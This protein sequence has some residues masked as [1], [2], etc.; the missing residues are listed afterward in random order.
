M[1]KRWAL[2][3][4]LVLLF[5]GLS[6]FLYM[7]RPP[8]VLIVNGERLELPGPAAVSVSANLKAAGLELGPG[9]L[10]SPPEGTWSWNIGQITIEQSAQ[11]SIYADGELIS[12]ASTSRQAGELVRQA[13]LQLGPYD[14]LY[15]NGALT[16]PEAVMDFQP[17]RTIDLRRAVQVRLDDGQETLA[18]YTT[19]ATLGEALWNEGLLIR[20]GDGLTPGM[21]AGLDASEGSEF[22]ARLDRG[23][24]VTIEAG[25]EILR[26]VTAAETVSEALADGGIR[27]Q[28]RD[29]SQPA[30]DEP[31]PVNRRLRV[32]RVREEIVLEQEP[33]SFESEY[34]PLPEL[35]LDEKQ[36]I[37]V[38]EYG[39]LARRVRVIYQNGVEVRREPEGEWIARQP[40][41]RI[42]GYGT[43]V[44][45]HTID[46]PDGQIQYW[47][48]LQMWATSYHPSTTSSR[49]AS[50][51]PLKKGVAAVDRRIIPFYTR[52]Y[53]PGYGEAVAADVGGGVVGRMIDLGYSDE[54][55]VS[56]HDWVTVYFL[57]PPPDN[58][59]WMVP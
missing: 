50:G 58:I 49:T 35:D 43:R 42:V 26:V 37:Q 48:A 27:L 30:E 36:V 29:Y 8:A 18:F 10:V 44:V 24:L 54:D 1:R 39:L 38:G 51:L 15:V 14:Q 17:A 34:Q 11:V 41:N 40:K 55:Y 52:M 22:S 25:G 7:N 6:I 16:D 59:I 2:P 28:G 33:L 19:A 32:V 53:I 9:D 4:T 13:G 45:M 3:I 12:L 21:E 31:L 57:W 20:N 23:L 47:R 5:A 56:W 46:T